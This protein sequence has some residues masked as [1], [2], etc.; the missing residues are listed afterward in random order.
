M[1]ESVS[2]GRSG[3]VFLVP[4]QFGQTE[5]ASSE[6]QTC[7]AVRGLQVGRLREISNQ[8]GGL[9]KS[10]NESEDESCERQRIE[11]GSV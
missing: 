3:S 5:T 4:V 11:A 8:F 7:W 6:L 9:Q 1:R 2:D 10:L